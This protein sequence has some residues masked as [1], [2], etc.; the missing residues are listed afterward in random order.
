[1]EIDAYSLALDYLLGGSLPLV[2]DLE[3]G[4]H[5]MQVLPIDRTAVASIINPD[6]HER[7]RFLVAAMVTIRESVEV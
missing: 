6:Q 5:V 1:M 4:M 7:L 3:D 2:F